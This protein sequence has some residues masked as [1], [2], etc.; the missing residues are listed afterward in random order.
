VKVY[1]GL[2]PT[3]PSRAATRYLQATA[4]PSP[5]SSASKRNIGAIAGGTVGGLLVLIALLCIVLFCLHR[6][7]KAKKD[8]VYDPPSAPPAEL[9]V[10]QFP[11]EMPTSNASKYV[12]AHERLNS[13]ELPGHSEYALEQSHT[14][15]Y[16]YAPPY[17]SDAAQTHGAASPYTD[18]YHGSPQSP[19]Y[20]HTSHSPL[21][22]PNNTEPYFPSDHMAHDAQP[23]LWDQ[24]SSLTQQAQGRQRQHSYPKPTSPYNTTNASV[25]QQSQVYYPPPQDSTHGTQHSPTFHRSSPADGHYNGDAQYGNTPLN[26]TT[27]TPANLYAQ[28]APEGVGSSSNE[29]G[30]HGHDPNNHL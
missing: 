17:A 6:R 22:S 24:Q 27:A 30:R 3:F 10:T 14:T 7:K 28:S 13:N 11:H 18:E 23:G 16:G 15:S 25:Q 20:G 8:S 21:R 1:Y 5:S 26:S 2:T 29:Y 9:A 12:S 19:G 4:S